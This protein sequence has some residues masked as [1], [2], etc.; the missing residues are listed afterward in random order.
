MYFQAAGALHCCAKTVLRLSAL[1]EAVKHARPF[2]L[3]G[4]MVSLASSP[5]DF[6]AIFHHFICSLF[7]GT[8]SHY[9]LVLLGNPCK[10]YQ[11]QSIKP[12]YCR[13]GATQMSSFA[14]SCFHDFPG[15][16]IAMSSVACCVLA[17]Q[18]CLRQDPPLI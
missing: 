15:W 18:S 6:F 10:T 13:A 2:T 12:G 3:S 4:G 17:A 16:T 14:A 11:Y 8:P 1:S 7:Q 9:S 5:H